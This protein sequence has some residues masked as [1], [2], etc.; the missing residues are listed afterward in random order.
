M[1]SANEARRLIGAALKS[2]FIC[3]LQESYL[4]AD[5]FDFVR[6]MGAWIDLLSQ[7]DLCV[8][9]SMGEICEGRVMPS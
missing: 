6:W 9:R 8:E 3:R 4:D 5:P 2:S 7:K 1:E